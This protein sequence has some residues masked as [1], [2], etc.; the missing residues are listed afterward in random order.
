[1]SPFWLWSY[2]KSNLLGVPRKAFLHT[3]R[4]IS[5]HGPFFVLFAVKCSATEF[6]GS[7]WKLTTVWRTMRRRQ[8]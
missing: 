5:R 4:E 7:L 1:M 2:E 6:F 8:P 3:Y